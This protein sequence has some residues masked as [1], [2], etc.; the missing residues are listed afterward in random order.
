MTHQPH[1]PCSLSLLPSITPLSLPPC[2]LGGSRGVHV[3]RVAAGR[4]HKAFRIKRCLDEELWHGAG[5]FQ[6]R[7]QRWHG[8]RHW[9]RWGACSKPPLLVPAPHRRWRVSPLEILPL[10][11]GTT[12]PPPPV[13]HPSV[14]AP[15]E[16]HLAR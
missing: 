9:G 7:R 8:G 2:F 3:Q 10:A 16:R 11:A 4:Q 6:R 5:R 15:G 1:F 13:P 12:S 14:C